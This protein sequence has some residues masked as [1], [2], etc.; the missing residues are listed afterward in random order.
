M[1]NDKNILVGES[2]LC[3]SV[4]FFFFPLANQEDVYFIHV[5]YVQNAGYVQTKVKFIRLCQQGFFGELKNQTSS[6]NEMEVR[7]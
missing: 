3:S 6:L 4:A 2:C 1:S 7:N 5:Y